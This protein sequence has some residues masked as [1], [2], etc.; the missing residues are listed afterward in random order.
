[1]L[2]DKLFF[3]NFISVCDN[4]EL[5]SSDERKE[6]EKEAE[7]KDRRAELIAKARKEKEV[8]DRIK[9]QYES[10]HLFIGCTTKALV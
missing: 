8:N 6:A 3:G 2:S 1:M 4:F 7:V 9:V 10:I 5:L